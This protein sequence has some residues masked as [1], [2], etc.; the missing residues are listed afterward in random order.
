M[1]LTVHGAGD[2]L[3]ELEGDIIEEYSAVL[4]A[5]ETAILVLS[6]GALL[7][8]RGDAFGVWRITQLDGPLGDI[9]RAPMNDE[10]NYSDVF[11]TQD[12]IAWV[13]KGNAEDLLIAKR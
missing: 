6:N 11:R 1:P 7:E 12:N 4:E 3:I 9:T 13:I 2:D 8:V 5:N 10:S